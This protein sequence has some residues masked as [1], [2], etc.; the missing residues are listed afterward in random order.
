MMTALLTGLE[1]AA[2]YGRAAEGALTEATCSCGGKRW[3]DDENW[4]P[5]RWELERGREPESGLLPCGFCNEGGWDTPV[6]GG[7]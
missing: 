2:D 7:G 6:G 5:E 1:R 3:V 4:Q